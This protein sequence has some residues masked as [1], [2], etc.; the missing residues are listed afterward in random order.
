MV[1]TK[2]L[3]TSR[4]KVKVGKNKRYNK[5]IILIILN[6]KERRSMVST[7]EFFCGKEEEYLE[8]MNFEILLKL[9]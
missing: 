1:S 9:A 4:R 3:K 6:T 8:A 2:E 5:R 7:K